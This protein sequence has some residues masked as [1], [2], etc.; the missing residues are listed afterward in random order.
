MSSKNNYWNTYQQSSVLMT[1]FTDLL[2]MSE[3]T[4]KSKIVLHGKENSEIEKFPSQVEIQPNETIKIEKKGAFPVFFSSYVYKRVTKKNFGDAFEIESHFVSGKDHWNNDIV[5]DTLVA[6]N[7]VRL[8]VN[9][10]VKQSDAEYV[11][12]EIP[13]PASCSYASKSNYWGETYREYFKE[14]TVIFMER[15]PK[16]NYKFYV[17]LLPRFSGCYT[18][19]PAKIELMYVPVVN[20]NNDM[21]KAVIFP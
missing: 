15:M 13:I 3:D 1:V 8:K 9:V 2:Q 6:G 14:K 21:K 17:D 20:S 18:I 5:I 4:G 16:G 12:L 11:M 19:N 7:Q 10:Q